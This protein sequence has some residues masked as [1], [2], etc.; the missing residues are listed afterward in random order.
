MRRIRKPIGHSSQEAAVT[1]GKR[2][3]TIRSGS[4][5][6]SRRRITSSVSIQ[7]TTKKVPPRSHGRGTCHVSR[8][9]TVVS[10]PARSSAWTRTF[11]VVRTIST[12]PAPER[13]RARSGCSS[14]RPR[15]LIGERRSSASANDSK[16]R[17]AP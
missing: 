15:I 12:S 6:A 17:N 3:P 2:L 5:L 1:R 9:E 10:R 4:R 7:P 11:V 13:R 14:R 8:A 16:S